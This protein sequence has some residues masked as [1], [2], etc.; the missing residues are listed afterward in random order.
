M[1]MNPESNWDKLIRS[2]KALKGVDGASS[3]HVRAR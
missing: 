3:A 2:S 1:A